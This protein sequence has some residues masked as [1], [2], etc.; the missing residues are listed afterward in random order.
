MTLCSLTS[1][2]SVGAHWFG[3]P[4]HGCASVSLYSAGT[5]ASIL[6]L[7]WRTMSVLVTKLVLAFEV[8]ASIQSLF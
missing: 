5:S 2:D 1:H 3:R 7:Y 4:V 8:F 6:S